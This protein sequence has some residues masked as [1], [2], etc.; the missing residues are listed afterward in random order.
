MGRPGLSPAVL[1]RNS[2]GTV[3]PLCSTNPYKRSGV[4]GFYAMRLDEFAP[5]YEFNEVHS[6]RVIAPKERVYAAI[7]AVTAEG[8][9]TE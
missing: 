4:K 3:R 9:A 6:I 1:R 7:K 8:S 5:S 2:V